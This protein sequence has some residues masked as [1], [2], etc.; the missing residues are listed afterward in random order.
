MDQ[1]SLLYSIYLISDKTIYSC[2]TLQCTLTLKINGHINYFISGYSSL[3]LV[4]GKQI[5]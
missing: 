5:S 4:G 2:Q 3:W 1:D